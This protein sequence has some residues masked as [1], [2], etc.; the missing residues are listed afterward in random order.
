MFSR[1]KRENG[2]LRSTLLLAINLFIYW[3]KIPFALRT[4]KVSETFKPP[5]ELYSFHELV[6]FNLGWCLTWVVGVGFGINLLPYNYR[7]TYYGSDTLWYFLRHF[8]LRN[9]VKHVYW[10]HSLVGSLVGS[11]RGWWESGWG[12]GDF[13]SNEKIGIGV[14]H[15]G[16]YTLI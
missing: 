8:F 2:Y 3:V 12:G 4:F 14:Y 7:G 5:V 15:T 11:L 9:L 10:Q 6:F 13:S 16:I 1:W